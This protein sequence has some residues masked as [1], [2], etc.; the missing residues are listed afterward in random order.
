MMKKVVIAINELNQRF[1]TALRNPGV[2]AIKFHSKLKQ[3]AM[4]QNLPKTDLCSHTNCH[5]S[6]IFSQRF[7]IDGYP[8]IHPVQSID[9]IPPKPPAFSSSKITSENIIQCYADKEWKCK[10]K[11]KSKCPKIPNMKVDGSFFPLFNEP[12]Y[13]MMFLSQLTQEILSFHNIDS[14][15]AP[16]ILAKLVFC[17]SKK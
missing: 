16:A 8:C 1:Q 2:Q 10:V 15:F 9:I 11:I 17:F 4:N 12:D 13:T 14:K 5:W 3:K 6:D 7:G